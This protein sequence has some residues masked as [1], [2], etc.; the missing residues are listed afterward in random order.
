MGFKLALRFGAGDD[1]VEQ[2]MPPPCHHGCHHDYLVT[3][4]D[5]GRAP[6]P[7]LE[8]YVGLGFA[9][10]YL[11]GAL[12]EAW[13]IRRHEGASRGLDARSEELWTSA[14]GFGLQ[15][16]A[17]C[18]WEADVAPDGSVGAPRTLAGGTTEFSDARRRDGAVANPVAK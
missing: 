10:L 5:R 16:W 9:A 8:L 15:H 18:Q 3:I 4:S 12:K 13:A 6:P 17:G 1:L 2:V 7:Q 14:G 11:A